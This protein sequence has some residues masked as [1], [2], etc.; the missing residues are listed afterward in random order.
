[1][2]AGSLSSGEKDTS[3]P[4][5]LRAVL[6]GPPGAGKGTQALRIAE[7]FGVPPIATGDIFRANVK[8]ETELGREAKQ[9]MDKGE[10]VPDEVVVKMVSARLAEDDTADGFLLDGFPRTVPQAEALES[11]LADADRQLH[12]VLRFSIKDDEVV[13]RI[14]G[15]RVCPDCGAT[16]HVEVEPPAQE[17]ICDKC[18]AELIQRGDDTEEV[19]RNRLDVYHRETQPL[20]FFYWERGLLRDVEAVGDVTEVT[21]RTLAALKSVF[22]DNGQTPAR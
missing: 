8:G 14:A 22:S 3:G 4:A 17:G 7:T 16:Y 21:E 13:R 20:E 11:L 18:G 2:S 5:G 10:L 9:Y 15:R 1:M 19:V 6:L 12:A